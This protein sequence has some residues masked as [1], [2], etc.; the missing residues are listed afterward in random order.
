MCA[1]ESG[2]LIYQHLLFCQF[3]LIYIDGNKLKSGLKTGIQ[4]E[5][6]FNVGRSNLD[7]ME[8]NFY[9]IFDNRSHLFDSYSGEKRVPRFD[10]ASFS[11][12]DTD[13]RQLLIFPCSPSLEQR[14]GQG[15]DGF[16][17]KNKR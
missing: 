16:R 14:I 11:F 3:G 8:A 17:E 2:V 12:F 10:K 13:P 9:R 5:A 1:G 6:E 7:R 15:Q 4:S